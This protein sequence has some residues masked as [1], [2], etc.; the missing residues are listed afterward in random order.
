MYVIFRLTPLDG[1][2]CAD[3]VEITGCGFFSLDEIASMDKVQN[4]SHW[5]IGAALARSD[6]FVRVSEPSDIARPGYTLFG[7][8]YSR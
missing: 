2:P 5:A 1:E 7:L 4:L 8:E 6:G 3:G